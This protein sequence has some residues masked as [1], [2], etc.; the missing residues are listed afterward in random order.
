MCNVAWD[1]YINLFDQLS[2]TNSSVQDYLAGATTDYDREVW[3]QGNGTKIEIP[4]H[5]MYSQANIGS[6]FDVP[7]VWKKYVKAPNDDLLSVNKVDAKNQVRKSSI[8][9]DARFWKAQDDIHT[10]ERSKTI[11]STPWG[12]EQRR[13]GTRKGYRHTYR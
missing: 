4:T 9:N 12:G 8:F 10:Q 11:L 3:D 7:G 13:C 6:Q 5:V 2:V 1:I